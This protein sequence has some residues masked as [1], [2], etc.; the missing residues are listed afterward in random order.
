[1]SC[2][3]GT[4]DVCTVIEVHKYHCMCKTIESVHA[5]VETIIT[6]RITPG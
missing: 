3:Q 4:Q 2:K 6:Q 5:A 1:V